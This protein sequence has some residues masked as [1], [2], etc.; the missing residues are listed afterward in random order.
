MP[1]GTYGAVKGLT[2]DVLEQLGAGIVLANTYHLWLRPGVETISELGGLHRFCGWNRPMLTD[3]GGFQVMSLS[4][5][6]KISE[7]GVQFRSHLDGSAH[8]LSPEESVSAQAAFGVDVAMVLDE[9]IALPAGRNEVIAAMERTHRW[10]ARSRA[11][12]RGPGHLFAI[13][14]GGTEPDLRRQSAL[15]LR[16]MDFPGYAIGGLAVGEAKSAMDETVRLTADLLPDDR[17]R[18]LMGVGTPRDIVRAVA[19]GV[20]MFD[21]VL[22]TR[23]ARNGYLFTSRGLVRIKRAE[24][25]RDGGPIDPECR[26]PTCLRYSRAYLR[27]L[28]MS[29]D[30]T[31]AVLLSIHNVAFYLDFMAQIREAIASA[32][33]PALVQKWS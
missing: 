27:H 16:E 5:F 32:A 28:F 18:Y 9:C 19:S 10:A 6:R 25:A 4:G 30:L 1:V 8:F 15:T 20:D 23:N 14:Q 31:A 17:P 12:Y 21:C 26:C 7:E 22:P 11:A 24:F 33:L 13:V 29:R 3:S 2:G